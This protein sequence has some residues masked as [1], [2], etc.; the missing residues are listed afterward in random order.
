LIARR[1]DLSMLPGIAARDA[2][3]KALGGQPMGDLTNALNL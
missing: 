2:A 1:F 3:L